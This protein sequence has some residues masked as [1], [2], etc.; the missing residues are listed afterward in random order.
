MRIP[1]L[2]F[3]AVAMLGLSFAACAQQPPQSGDERRQA[4]R[5]RLQTA[6]TDH[7]GAISKAEADAGLPRIAK[8]FDRIDADH[9]GR[10]T[11]DELKAVAAQFAARRNGAQQ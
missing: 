2:P 8:N 3:A 5:D 1:L 4:V 10:I 9:D 6:D 7:D 11:P